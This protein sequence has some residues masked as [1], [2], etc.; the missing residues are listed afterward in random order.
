[1]RTG[2]WKL[3]HEKKFTKEGKFIGDEYELYNINDDPDEMKNRF[4]KD[5]SKTNEL[6]AIL[7]KWVKECYNYKIKSGSKALPPEI[8]EEAKKRGYW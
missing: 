2:E 7:E 4:D 5:V 3:I 1:M 6:K 8:A